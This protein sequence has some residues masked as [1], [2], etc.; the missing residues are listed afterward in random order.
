MSLISILLVLILEQFQALPAKRLVRAPFLRL[1]QRVM[2]Y[3]NDGEYRNGALGWGLLVAVPTFCVL[4]VSIVLSLK[5]PFWAFVFSLGVLYLTLGLR[6]FSNQFT[7]IQSALTFVEV[8]RA[9]TLLATW[10]G[11][12]AD[13][14]SPTEIAGSAI[15]RGLD[16]AHQHVFAPIFWFALIGPAGA[17]LYRT[18]QLLD[19]SWG[20]P[21]RASQGRPDA[22]NDGRYGEFSHLAFMV[23]DWIPSRLTA[24]A[25]AV[26]GD[27]ED[28]IQCW[29]NQADQTTDADSAIVVASGAGA[30]G[31]RLTMVSSSMAGPTGSYGAISEFGLG[32]DADSNGMQRAAALVWRALLLF[33]SLLALILVSS[34]QLSF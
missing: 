23:I 16:E 18:A 11:R 17:L 29:R 10:R 26:V 5:E 8:E 33:L 25:F 2:Q 30:L 14:L 28:A 24:L 27:F 9:R 7:A 31:V 6:H 32:D 12:N 19:E 4:V 13:R 34:W 3:F 21:W 22:T 1:A 20:R 15:V